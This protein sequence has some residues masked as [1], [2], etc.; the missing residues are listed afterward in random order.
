MIILEAAA[1]NASS[2]EPFSSNN[3]TDTQE[4]IAERVDAKHMRKKILSLPSQNR[5]PMLQAI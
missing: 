1:D 5:P 3:S 4:S 2:C